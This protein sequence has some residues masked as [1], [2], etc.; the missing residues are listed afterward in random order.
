MINMPALLRQLL[1]KSNGSARRLALIDDA[2]RK[3]ERAPGSAGGHGRAM[4]GTA[5]THSRRERSDR[6]EHGEDLPLAR[7]SG[8]ARPKPSCN[9]DMPNGRRGK[10][11]LRNKVHWIA[12]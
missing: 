2:L 8:G 4:R 9:A 12:A 6:G 5:A 10:G 3:V 1:N 7:R 11:F